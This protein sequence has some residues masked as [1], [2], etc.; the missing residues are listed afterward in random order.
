MRKSILLL[1]FVSVFILLSIPVI[2]SA[3]YNEYKK[4][5]EKNQLNNI[6]HIIKSKIFDIKNTGLI[7]SILLLILQSFYITGFVVF[8]IILVPLLM[9]PNPY[10]AFDF[11]WALIYGFMLSLIWPVLLVGLI[12]ELNNMKKMIL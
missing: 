9:S 10:F 4:E 2:P 1:T 5:I 11:L 6:K 3:Q 7:I 12:R 8:F